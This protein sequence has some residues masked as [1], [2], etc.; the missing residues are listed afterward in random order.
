MPGETE[1]T[2]RT[3]Q[4][5]FTLI[6]LM[7]VVAIIGILAAIAIP[8][9]LD[10]AIRTQV[11]HGLN[12]VA[13]AKVAVAEYYQDQ[14]TFPD[15][16]ATAGLSPPATISGKYITQVE[17]IG[18]GMIEMTYGGDVNIKIINAKLT[19]QA[20]DMNGSVAWTCSGDAVLVDKWLPPACRI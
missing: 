7:I 20:F 11:S 4:R 1:A 10:Y 13:G 3:I 18:G 14:G 5:G 16:N 12:L 19:M 8:M 2:L 15:D 6:E 9:Y 17:V